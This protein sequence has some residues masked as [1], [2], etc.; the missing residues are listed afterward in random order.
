MGHPGTTGQ[1]GDTG[2]RGNPG[3]LGPLGLR[4]PVGKRGLQGN[5]G[6]VG[7]PGFTGP[8]G[9]SGIPGPSGPLGPPGLVHT[10][11]GSKGDRGLPGQM[12][13]C[14]CSNHAYMQ[15]KDYT[16]V[17]AI[18]IVNTEEEMNQLNMED[19]MALRK[20]TQTLYFNGKTGWDSIQAI[21]A[22]SQSQCG[23][24]IIQFENGEQCDDG[25][26]VFSDNCISCRRAFCGDG[27]RQEGLEEC[28]RS[29][30]GYQTCSS[31]LPGS[32]GNL[33]CS[34]YCYIDSTDC[35]F[36]I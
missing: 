18:F 4:G 10:L 16:E 3:L 11:A 32:Y 36:F 12:E 23:D 22:I 26:Q 35:R 21:L 5:K 6:D 2:P 20:D 33:K 29:D 13:K 25:N 30:F 28:D 14:L 9:A 1:K 8:Q 7:P 31:Y 15:E 17:L 27:Y 34:N 24:G 19:V